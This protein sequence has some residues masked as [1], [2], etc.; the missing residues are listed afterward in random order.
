MGGIIWLLVV[1]NM[2]L[3]N[4]PS[5]LSMLSVADTSFLTAR[6]IQQRGPRIY[7]FDLVFL[8]I[9]ARKLYVVEYQLFQ[10]CQAWREYNIY[11]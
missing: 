8:E 6:S 11:R 1:V 4:K 2:A 7:Y 10:D 3:E 9:N 5:F